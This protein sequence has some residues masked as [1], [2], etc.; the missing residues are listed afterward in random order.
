[1]TI[2]DLLKKNNTIKQGLLNNHY[3]LGKYG[4]FELTVK[5]WYG[6][7]NKKPINE[8]IISVAT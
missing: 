6:Y 1:M 2:I 7:L 8:R 3:F 4:L 5:N